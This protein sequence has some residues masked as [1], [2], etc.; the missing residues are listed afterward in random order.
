MP[1]NTIIGAG[2]FI[3]I[4]VAIITA[5]VYFIKRK[6]KEYQSIQLNG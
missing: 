4:P 2:I 3:V 6:K 5:I 1:L